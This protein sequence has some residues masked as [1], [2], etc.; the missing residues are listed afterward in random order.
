[1]INGVRLK[2]CGITSLVDAEAADAVGA[3]YLGFIFYPQSPRAVSMTQYQ[4]MSERLPPRKRVAVLV[5]PSPA[6]LAAFVAEDFDRFQIH[7]NA[8]T[9]L[10]AIAA[11]SQL[12]GRARLWLAPKLPPA[13]DVTPEWLAQ[14]ETFLL[15]TF[16]AEKFGGTGETGDWDKFKRH[17]LTHAGKTWI[18]SGGLNPEN[19]AAAVTATGSRF[20][21]VNS[22]VEQAP[23]VKSPAKL[24]AF[25]LA[26]HN[27]TKHGNPA[28]QG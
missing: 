4:A 9:P 25:V 1:M 26:L 19:I 6:E 22:G 3:D 16:H 2:V 14:A 5:E 7:F 17:H 10:A 27:A 8:T 28:Y 11:W 23:G 21:D 12:V 15:D 20:V 18:L 13:Q 24:K